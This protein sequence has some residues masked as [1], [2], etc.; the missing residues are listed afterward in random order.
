MR[1]SAAASGVV[2]LAAFAFAGFLPQIASSTSFCPVAAFLGFLGRGFGARSWPTLR[3]SASIR[4]TTLPMAPRS[5]GM[6]GVRRSPM[7]LFPLPSR[8]PVQI[9][10]VI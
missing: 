1:T 10:K 3:S 4:S 7:A 9:Q 5:L 2:F 6:S 8:S